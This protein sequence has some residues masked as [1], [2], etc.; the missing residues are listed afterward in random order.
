M[1]FSSE[2]IMFLKNT[3]DFVQYYHNYYH[4]DDLQ[5]RSFKEMV[6]KR[7]SLGEIIQHK[8]LLSFIGIYAIIFFHIFTTDEFRSGD[9]ET[10]D[11]ETIDDQQCE[12]D[13][14]GNNCETNIVQAEIQYLSVRVNS[15]TTQPFDYVNSNDG[16]QP[17]L[18]NNPSG[19]I[20][21]SLIYMYY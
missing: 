2:A 17:M 4:H 19:I 15:T 11:G 13:D 10:D 9:E 20:K 18:D 6:D 14:Y 3:D 1:E 21:F 12:N 5:Y 7:I 8:S 16:L